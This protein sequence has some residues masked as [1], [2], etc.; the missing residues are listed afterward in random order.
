MM[1]FLER[2]VPDNPIAWFVYMAE[3]CPRNAL[4]FLV[5]LYNNTFRQKWIKNTVTP[6][7]VFRGWK[8]GTDEPDWTEIK[9]GDMFPPTVPGGVWKMERREK[10]ANAHMWKVYAV[11]YNFLE[12]HILSSSEFEK[13][14]DDFIRLPR[15]F[16]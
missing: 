6:F 2:M 4:T 8:V 14:K 5:C 15:L 10:Y 12:E 3:E 13:A 1:S 9:T 11:I 7:K 16:G